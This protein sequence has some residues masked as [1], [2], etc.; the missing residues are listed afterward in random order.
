MAS[1]IHSHTQNAT[2]FKRVGGAGNAGGMGSRLTVTSS[3][4]P[5]AVDPRVKLQAAAV[6]GLQ[7]RRRRRRA[8]VPPMYS[9]AVVRVLS[10]KG[11][12]LE[13]HVVDL[14]ETG[15]AVQVDSV[16]PVGQGVTVEFRVSG[17]GRIVREEWSEF[18]AAA[19]VVRH[20]DVDDFPCGPYKTALRFVRIGTMAQAQ[21]ARFVATHPD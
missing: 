15:M 1:I 13:G 6:T 7:E 3:R 18:A 19:V 16:I 4:V 8:Q 20:D 11:D 17:L 10:Q 9:L 21:I 14:S 5:P 12:P 2:S